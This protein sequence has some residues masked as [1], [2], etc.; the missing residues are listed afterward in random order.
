VDGQ[1]HRKH[2]AI[3]WSSLLERHPGISRNLVQES[4]PCTGK[5]EKVR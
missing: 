4:A 1:C 2:T 5:G 3:A